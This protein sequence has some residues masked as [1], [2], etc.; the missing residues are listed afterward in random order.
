MLFRSAVTSFTVVTS[1]LKAVRDAEFFLRELEQRK[2]RVSSLIVNRVWPRLQLPTADGLAA[3]NLS[4]E[5]RQ[6]LQGTID[7][8]G[9]VSSSHQTVWNHLQSSLGTRVERLAQVP[10]LPEDIAGLPALQHIA[11]QLGDCA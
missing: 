6:L 9:A 2:F 5:S 3:G 8:Y 11:Q 4:D 7:W 10:E 1:P